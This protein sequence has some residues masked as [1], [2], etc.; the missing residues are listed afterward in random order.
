MKRFLTFLCCLLIAVASFAQNANQHL[1]F[2]GVP[3]NGS[4]TQFQAKLVAKG[5]SY[6]QTES[7]QSANGCRIFY[8][9]LI[10]NKVRICVFYNTLTKSV[11]RVKAIMD[12]LSEDYVDQQYSKI[13]GLLAQKYDYQ[14]E[15]TEDDKESVSFLSLRDPG[16]E[17][18]FNNVSALSEVAFGEVDLFITKDEESWRRSPYNFNLHIDYNDALNSEKNDNSMLDEL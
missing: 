11:Y 3:I 5:C 10:G 4:I 9:T 1:K 13:K 2:M 14:T 7:A 17:V 12:G 15:G 16:T 18:D 8:G 6:N